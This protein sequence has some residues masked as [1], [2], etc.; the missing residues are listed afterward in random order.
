MRAKP[1]TPD[2]VAEDLAAWVQ[3]N[4]PRRSESGLVYCLTRKD[5]EQARGR[6]GTRAGGW[7]GWRAGLAAEQAGGWSGGGRAGN[8]LGGRATFWAGGPLGLPVPGPYLDLACSLLLSH[9][10]EGLA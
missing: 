9:H 4:F 6:A 3:G 8:V 1:A 7:A 10:F 5:C 2:A